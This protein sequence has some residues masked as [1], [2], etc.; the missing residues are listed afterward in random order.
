MAH[1]TKD[2]GLS[3]RDVDNYLVLS[4]YW[5][6]PAKRERHQSI[7]SPSAYVLNEAADLSATARALYVAVQKLE[8]ELV[9]LSCLT[10]LRE[11]QAQW[12]RYAKSASHRLLRPGQAR[13]SQIPPILKID[14][15]RGA[16]GEWRAVEVDSYNA[17]ALGTIV[18]CDGLLEHSSHEPAAPLAKNLAHL[19]A[20]VSTLTIIISEK[21]EYYRT[22]FEIVRDALIKKGVRTRLVN[23]RHIA[24]NPAF[25]GTSDGQPVLLI[26]P[27][28]M[29]RYPEARQ[30]LMG[31]Y[32]SGRIAVLY[33]PKPY[34]GAKAFLPF[35]AVQDGVVGVI[36]ATALLTGQLD[37]CRF[38]PSPKAKRF[39]LKHV[40][41]S[42]SK[43]L[44]RE[45]D[46]RGA[47][48]KTIKESQG[49][50]NP[51]WVVQE[52]VVQEP[53]P[54]TVFEG[55]ER[56]TD[57]FYLRLTMYVGAEGIAGIK[58]TGRKHDIVHGAADCVQLP[59]IRSAS[60]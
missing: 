12:L 35:L 4:G 45:G 47:Y 19:L 58:M 7:L 28:N 46:D 50:R 1:L 36:P 3:R 32:R 27:E 21:E 53:I 57:L 38:Y 16:G 30:K 18:L 29:H 17:R 11:E 23:E 51:L 54:L 31:D 9:E 49:A 52:E 25:P 37:S 20:E 56:V 10:R 44:I 6:T 22:S 60:K 13:C 48:F 26:I 42:G 43:G 39:I 55:D 34:L 15:V 5:S 14:M 8:R 40:H 41:S 33:P 59:V 2:L 24:T